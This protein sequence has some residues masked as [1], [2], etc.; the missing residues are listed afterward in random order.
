MAETISQGASFA[1][2]IS[3]PSQVHSNSEHIEF[4][5]MGSNQEKSSNSPETEPKD[6]EEEDSDLKIGST[7]IPMLI[8][9]IVLSFVDLFSDTWTGLSLLKLKDKLW[10]GISLAINWI[11]GAVGAIQIIANHRSHGIAKTV[12]YCLA[13]VV[14]C[15]IVPT[16][17][18]LYLWCKVPQSSEERKSRKFKEEFQKILSFVTLVRALEGCIESPLQLLYKTFLMFNGVIDFNFTGET[19]SYQDIHGNSVSV[20]FF[21]NF[22]I[23]G[24]TL[25]KSVYGLNMPFFKIDKTSKFSTVLSWID[26]VGFL[27]T[28]ALFRIGALIL[29]WGYFNY[30]AIIPML[31]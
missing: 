12:L 30:S 17:T 4:Q 10:G 16:L 15:P 26:C 14:L 3:E 28:S 9:E 13:S 20:P 8:V 11:P 7:F 25:I 6:Q 24:L 22:M 18:Y 23:S 5:Y 29:L 21:I 2:G 19:F 31:R 1:Q 27:V